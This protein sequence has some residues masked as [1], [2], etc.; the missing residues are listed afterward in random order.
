MG[1]G[2]RQNCLQTPPNGKDWS[3][4]NEDPT[5]WKGSEQSRLENRLILSRAKQLSLTQKRSSFRLQSLPLYT[6]LGPGGRQYRLSQ[7]YVLRSL[8]AISVWE[9]EMVVP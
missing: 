8:A 3:Y 1:S 5:Q 9:L 6:N 4:D 7:P 2:T